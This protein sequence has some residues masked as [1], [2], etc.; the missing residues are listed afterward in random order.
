M[1]DKINE[2]D[3]DGGCKSAYKNASKKILEMKNEDYDRFLK[4]IM[5]KVN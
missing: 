2:Y 1:L 3:E 4:E 5:K